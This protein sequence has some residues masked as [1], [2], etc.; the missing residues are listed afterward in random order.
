M[1]DVIRACLLAVKE[2]AAAGHPINDETL[3]RVEQ[4]IR[5][6]YNGERVTVSKKPAREVRYQRYVEDIDAGY[7]YEQAAQRHG[8]SKRTIIRAGKQ[9]GDQ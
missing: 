4:R 2:E 3:L 7:T 9:S 6:E 5:H 8:V 1:A